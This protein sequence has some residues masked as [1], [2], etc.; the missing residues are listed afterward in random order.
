MFQVVCK[1]LYWVLMEDCQ[2]ERY[3]K[4][5]RLPVARLLGPKKDA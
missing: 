2:C 3:T 4:R 1:F 5:I